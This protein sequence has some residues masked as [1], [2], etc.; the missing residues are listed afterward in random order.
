MTAP[1]PPAIATSEALVKRLEVLK[2]D[3]LHPENVQAV[4]EAIER[5]R[6]EH[7]VCTGCGSSH[8]DSDYAKPGPPYACCPERKMLT[9]KDLY[10]RLSAAEEENKRLRAAI[11]WLQPPF[12]DAKTPAAEIRKRICFMLDDLKRA[13]R[14]T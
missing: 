14:E 1:T 7:R 6:E 10:A 11:S 5:L 13:G 3:C 9:A 4:G 8:P 2:A 12:V